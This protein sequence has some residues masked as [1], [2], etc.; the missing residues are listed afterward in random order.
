MDGRSTGGERR[1]VRPACPALGALLLALL[2]GHRAARASAAAPPFAVGQELVCGGCPGGVANVSQVF[3][4]APAGALGLQTITHVASGLCVEN[5]AGSDLGFSPRLVLQNC[6][7]NHAHQLWNLSAAPQGG[8]RIRATSTPLQGCLGWNNYAGSSAEGNRISPYQCDEPNPPDEAFSFDAATGA[9]TVVQFAPDHCVTVEVATASSPAGAYLLSDDAPGALSGVVFDGVGVV[10]AGGAARLLFDYDPAVQSRVLDALFLPAAVGGLGA[11]LLRVEIGGDCAVLSGAE[12]A[13]ERFQGEPSQAATRGTQ[14]WL[15]LQA[16]ARNAAIKVLAVPQAWP[17][18]LAANPGVDLSPFGAP[19]RAAAYVADWVAAAAAAGLRV[20]FVGVYDGFWDGALSPA[21]VK[22]LRQELNARGGGVAACGIVCGDGASPAA[23]ACSKAAESDP[24]L[25]E[26]VAAFGEHVAP[27]PEAALAGWPAKG[28][29]VT[30]FASGRDANLRDAADLASELNRAALVANVTGF[31]S[32][33]AVSA[34]YNTLPGFRTGAVDAPQPWS[35]FWDITPSWYALAHTAQ[36]NQPGFVMLNSTL[37]SGELYRGGTYVTRVDPARSGKFSVVIATMGGDGAAGSSVSELASFRL[38]GSLLAGAQAYGNAV[39]AWTTCFGGGGGLNASFFEKS[40]LE[41]FVQGGPD[42]DTV[43]LWLEPNCVVTLT[44]VPGAAPAPPPGSTPAVPT[45]FFGRSGANFSDR[46]LGLPGALWADVHGAFEVVDSA[47][48]GGS[49]LQQVAQLPRPLSAAAGL[50]TAVLRPHTV[51]GDATWRDADATVR[52]FLPGVQD[53][54]GLGLRVSSFN[55]SAA[56]TLGV[57][58]G[59]GVWL[60]VCAAGSSGGGTSGWSTGAPTGNW[61]LLSNLDLRRDAVEAGP[62]VTPLLPGT[63]HT[64]RLVL[65]GDSAV[66]L[67][68]GAVLAR[69]DVPLARGFPTVGFMGLAVADF[70]GATLFSSYLVTALGT[71][72]S[73]VPR[74]GAEPKMEP[75]QGGTP[76]QS[77]AFSGTPGRLGDPTGGAGTPGT[78]AM[79]F[80]SSLCLQMENATSPDY[81][82]QRT[83]RVWLAACAAGEA[84]QQ[85]TIEASTRDG[86]DD[87]VGPVQGVDGGVLNLYRWEEVDDTPVRAYPWQASSNEIFQWD[88]VSG[89]LYVPYEGLCVSFCES[90]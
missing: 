71:T 44:T 2:G 76:G 66:C 64:L 23:W 70:G 56:G 86:G 90:E 16:Q 13:H 63:W 8:T 61:V 65:R 53:C 78:L 84:R 74:Q 39:D 85:F 72:C 33:S 47:A 57:A 22:A 19:Q 82:Y 73:A 60:G 89:S 34:S 68:D 59:S 9:I 50:A 17:G 49:A 20:D 5:W 41:L 6:L 36:F 24:L 38:G 1:P 7:A 14:V 48:A 62:L 10:A 26:A 77:F 30:S 54:V 58:D 18:W 42:A 15:A 83:K 69:V 40:S 25:A 35:G 3:A 52:F 81:G 28:R 55:D 29:W 12:P 27:A 80:N 51:L 75:C 32:F 79:E 45:A 4:M 11:Q 43:S 88:A 37:G 31:L 46:S 21:Y 67:L 87:Y